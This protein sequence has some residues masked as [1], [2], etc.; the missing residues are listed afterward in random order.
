MKLYIA[1]KPSLGRAIADVLP[2][3]HRRDEGCIWVGDGDCVS[4]CIGHLLEQV[5]PDAYNPQFKKWAEQDLPIVPEHWQLIPKASTRKQLTVLRKLIKQAEELIHAG[6]PDREGQL[7]VDEVINYCGVNK[8]KMASTQRL[9]IS[10][11][12]PAAVRKALANLRDNREF[13]PLSTSALARSR[14][15]WLYGINL[16]RA[17]TLQ[18]RK[19]G[20][21][22][23]LSVG[24]VQTPLLG[25][26]V[27]RDQDIDNFRSK[28]FYEVL[29]K[30]QT[31]PSAT[32]S[33]IFY[34]KWLPSDACQP[35]MDEEGRVLSKAL[36]ENVVG[37]ISEQPGEVVAVQNT[38]VRQSPPLPYSLSALQIDAG[39]RFGMS[40]Q[41]ILDICQSLY[42]R[43]KLITYPRSDSRHLP[44][45]HYAQA[46]SILAAM[47]QVA[48]HLQ[49]AIANADTRL[50]S[51]AWDDTKVNAH[52]AIIPTTKVMPLEKLNAQEAKVYA[53]IA[54]Q[55]LIQFYPQHTFNKTT[56]DISIAGGNF[57]AQAKVIKDI[58]WKVLFNSNKGNSENADHTADSSNKTPV[59]QDE[60]LS[61]QRLPPLKK[62][63]TLHCMEGQCVEKNTQ[64][65]KP[66][67]DATLL[68]AMTG[69][70]RYVS[71]SKIRKVLK[72]TDGLGTEATRA[73]II[74]L[75]FRR[76]FLRR[77]GKQIHA[78]EAGRGLINSLPEST[79]LPDMTAQWEAVLND[80]VTEQATYR[81]FMADLIPSLHRLVAESCAT[82]PF[83][84]KGVTANKPTYRKGRKKS[85]AAKPRRKK[86]TI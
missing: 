78:T 66:F 31:K 60:E 38:P 74:E 82:L 10:D 70:A 1:E 53:L 2:K 32:D 13:I 63:D 75:L 14:A 59:E 51:K 17:S 29:A 19:V 23:V 50:K 44:S 42:E 21:T 81:H 85:S 40:A 8:A 15:D 64:P 58:G 52:H 9:L 33:A 41:E 26:V 34:A 55:Y 79:T 62:G 61:E 5:E 6:D 4:W 12:N 72:D 45:E 35:Y 39:K 68:A 73:G 56:L 80:I 67:T 20:Y 83:A 37:R 48:P 22:G 77:Q 28:L 3:P 57:R 76:D 69:I 24:R 47:A 11:L 25:L 65:P 49:P 71:D 30:L 27:K 36:A 84:L 16:T 86:T 54:R 43:H 7:L 46:S 18:G